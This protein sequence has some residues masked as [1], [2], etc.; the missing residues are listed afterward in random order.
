VYE[1]GDFKKFQEAPSAIL[2]DMY[3]HSNPAA[4]MLASER[5]RATVQSALSKRTV[6]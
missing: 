4:K 1:A 5:W 6:I 2:I 3:C